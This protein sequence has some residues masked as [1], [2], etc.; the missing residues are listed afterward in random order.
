[1]GQTK[2]NKIKWHIQKEKFLKLEEINEEHI[3]KLVPKQLRFV[4]KPANLTYIIMLMNMRENYITE[5]N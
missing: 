1:M 4:K 5:G 2:N 3:I